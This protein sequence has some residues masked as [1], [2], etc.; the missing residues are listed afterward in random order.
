MMTPTITALRAT[1]TAACARPA[2]SSGEAGGLSMTS[3]LSRPRVSCG[4]FDDRRRSLDARPRTCAT[5]TEVGRFMTWLGDER[6]RDVRHLRRAAALVG[7]RPRGLLGRSLGVLRDPRAHALRR[8]CSARRTMP[9]AEWFPGAR[10]NYA[11]HL[12][13][14]RGGP[15][16]RRGRRP[17]ADPPA[18]RADLRRA[19]RSGRAG[20]APGCSGSGSSRGDRVVAYLPEHPRDAGGVHRH[21]QPGRDLG[22]LRARVRRP[23]RDRPVR[24]RSSPRC[25]S[26][27]AATATATAT[28]TA[29]PRS[30]RSGPALPTLEHV[31]GV[32]YGDAQRPGR[33]R[34]GGR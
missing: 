30:R 20:S 25:C 32:P 6:G 27:S 8:A 5:T 9:G 29:A 26:P 14:A 18:A 7:D 10:L 17:L 13:G 21:R 19:A 4:R 3:R 28:S 22:R 11:E 31:V 34:L 12:V 1:G 33:R 24:A 16:P 15:R 2:R 23:Q